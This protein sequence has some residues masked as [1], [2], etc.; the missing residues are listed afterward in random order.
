MVTYYFNSQPHKEADGGKTNAKNHGKI[1]S[2]HSLTRRLTIGT[3]ECLFLQCYFNSQPHKEADGIRSRTPATRL[4]FNSQPH[5]EA[6]CSHSQQISSTISFQFTASQGG[7]RNAAKTIWS[8]IISIHSLTRRLTV[9]IPFLLEERHFNSQPHKEADR[10]CAAWC[11]NAS[12]FQFTA[13]Q[14]GWQAIGNSLN[15]VFEISIHSLT[16]RL[17]R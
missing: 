6:D 7:W 13:S 4:H 1:I 5:K 16:R 14:G 17:T 10:E 2:I 11:S 8:G 9:I 15:G 12:V 3:K